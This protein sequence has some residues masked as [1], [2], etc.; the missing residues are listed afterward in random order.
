MEVKPFEIE[1]I[2]DAPIEAVWS[3]IT[4]KD[5]MRQWYF[6]LSDFKAEKGF[7]FEFAGKGNE[8]QDYIHH[9][10]VIEADA[11]KK[12]S[13]SWTYKGIEGYSVV[14]F[15]LQKEGEKTIVKLIHSGIESFPKH[16]DFASE[17]FAKGWSMLIGELLPEYFAKQIS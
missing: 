16:P 14:S 5:E 8:G 13:Y 4:D 1:Q 12:L 17:S 7:Q 6:D 15:E 10:T 2:V 11:L 9:C 3:A